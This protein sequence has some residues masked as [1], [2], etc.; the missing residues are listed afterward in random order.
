MDENA[1]PVLSPHPLTVELLFLWKLLALSGPSLFGLCAKVREDF[2]RQ[3]GPN[4]YG[5]YMYIEL[6]L[7]HILVLLINCCR[8]QGF[9]PCKL[10]D[11]KF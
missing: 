7:S 8:L 1:P 11:G 9:L 2:Q 3:G 6:L 5:L 4:L 10:N